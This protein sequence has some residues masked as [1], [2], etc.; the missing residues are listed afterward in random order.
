VTNSFTRRWFT[1]LTL[2]VLVAGCS[3]AVS[4]Q[5]EMEEALNYG[6]QARSVTPSLVRD[7]NTPLS[8]RER[9][10]HVLNRVTFGPTTEL[11]DEVLKTGVDDWLETQLEGKLEEPPEL[12]RRLGNLKSLPLSTQEIVKKY[13]DREDR[14]LRNVPSS[15]L[16][17]AVLL[18]A[19][20]SPNQLREVMCDFW[21]N[22]F[23]V[24]CSKGNVRYYA[25]TFERDV[26]RGEVLGSFER[27]L[28][29]EARHP[30][31]LIYLDNY[32]SRATPVSELRQVGQQALMNTR[33]YGA[34]LAAVD[35][36]K[37]RGI[38]ENYARELMELHTLGVDNFYSQDDV[39]TVANALTGWTVQQNAAK[40]P[41][42]FKFR[43]DM[44]ASENRVFLKK[45]LPSIPNSSEL[46]GQAVL[47]MLAKHRGTASYLSYKLCRYL[48]NDAPSEK[49]A[50]KAANTFNRRN[51]E[52]PD[53]YYAILDNKDFYE[54]ENYQAKFRRPFEFVVCALRVT[55]AEIG[56]TKQI[57]R[58][59]TSLSEPIYQCEDPT[60]YY[61][62]ADAW[63]DPGVMV[64]RWLFGLRLATGKLKGVKIPD[65]F[66]EE[67]EADNPQQWKELLIQRVLPGGCSKRTSDALDAYIERDYF[68]SERNPQW[69]G[70]EMLGLLLGSPEFQR[71]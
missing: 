11:I 60:G 43:P 34:A 23:N 39:I 47:N 48:V 8:E 2:C 63:R 33:D 30:A 1:S 38:N 57:H 12:L 65:S 70:G 66:W 19:V 67:F 71:Q 5:D 49:M 25:T 36:A 52:L 9:V 14:S 7:A 13:N 69:I 28:N 59:L 26:I 24:D 29:K 51:A 55:N 56:S 27:M 64:N 61:D 42:E 6:R 40:G 50:K 46:E 58:T 3:A 15:D 45:K 54:P 17:D 21:R 35:I 41:I 10:C 68:L 62:H 18:L 37:M 4:A 53:A 16:K 31:M 32:L 22:H 20:Y 44:H